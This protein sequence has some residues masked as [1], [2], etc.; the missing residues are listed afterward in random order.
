MK[1]QNHIEENVDSLIKRLEGQG[2]K[3]KIIEEDEE[4]Q[5]A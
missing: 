1:S 3:V 5:G 4:D 2:K